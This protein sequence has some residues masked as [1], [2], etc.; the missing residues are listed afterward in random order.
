MIPKIYNFTK[1]CQFAIF[2]ILS[3]KK[4]YDNTIKTYKGAKDG[5]YDKAILHGDV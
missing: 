4:D 5:R 2:L 3:L 1:I